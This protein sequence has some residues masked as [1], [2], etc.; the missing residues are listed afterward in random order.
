MVIQIYYL[1]YFILLYKP[2]LV[3]ALY[4]DRS[5]QSSNKYTVT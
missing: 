4:L 5:K 3:K 2:R 1:D